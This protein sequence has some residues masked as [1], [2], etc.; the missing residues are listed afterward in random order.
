LKPE[1]AWGID[2][3]YE[4]RLGKSGV[5]GVNVINRHVSDLIEFASTGDEG[6][7]GEGTFVLQPQTTGHGT[8]QCIEFA[9]ATPL[10]SLHM[11]NTG[12]NLKYSW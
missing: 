5:V 1:S 3:G 2:L 4:Y 7:A 11:P 9:V 10:S 6:S 8:V 12:I